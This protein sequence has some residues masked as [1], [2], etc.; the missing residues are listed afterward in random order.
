M[1]SRGWRGMVVPSLLLVA[2]AWSLPATAQDE[3]A[4]LRR[5]QREAE[6]LT[7][8]NRL[9]TREEQKIL[10]DLGELVARRDVAA[11]EKALADRRLARVST[12]SAQLDQEEIVAR[13]RE[14]E[15][16]TALAD[17][18]RRL[19]R[20]GPAAGLAAL[21]A[22][23]TP[24]AALDS[25]RAMTDAAEQDRQV[26]SRTRSAYLRA[27]DA[28]QESA[29]ARGELIEA[30]EQAEMARRQAEETLQRQQA[31][32]QQVRRDAELNGRAAAEMT[33]AAGRLEA[34]LAGDLASLPA[35]P[36]P[37]R[38]KGVLPWPAAGKVIQGFGPRRHPRFGTVVPHNGVA[39][40]AP[41]GADV[42]AVADGKVVFADWFQG[43]GRTVIVDHGGGIMSVLSHLSAVIVEV[44]QPVV[45]G[46][47]VG[48][49]GDSGSLEG[50]RLYFE[51]RRDGAPENPLGWLSSVP[52]A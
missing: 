26:I 20:L 27:R 47:M 32:L 21:A 2:A 51:L 16:R 8:Q 13:E 45:Q 31:R 42:R 35:G 14:R 3:E 17:R 39:I 30:R 24:A 50:A 6:I 49:V 9:L 48:L 1:R 25:L 40:G 28:G 11:A 34:F 4:R 44:G 22:A 38:L 12:T 10:V 19:E 46:Q 37:L 5:L 43:Y 23:P 33:A 29:A 41:M 18:L 7:R 15:A 36:D 52:D